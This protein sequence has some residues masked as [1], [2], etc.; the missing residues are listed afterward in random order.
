MIQIVG[1]V[2]GKLILRHKQNSLLQYA[3][4]FLVAR[5]YVPVIETY[6]RTGAV[7]VAFAIQGPPFFARQII[8]VGL[9]DRY[10][11]INTRYMKERADGRI[12]SP[13]FH[14][15]NWCTWFI[16]EWESSTVDIGTLHHNIWLLLWNEG[17]S[18]LSGVIIST[19]VEKICRSQLVSDVYFEP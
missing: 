13:L 19:N 12:N 17:F 3:E 6:E 11:H 14:D 15:K 5:Y 4:V 2:R 7:I 1:H 16:P 18:H 10:L 8:E 9:P